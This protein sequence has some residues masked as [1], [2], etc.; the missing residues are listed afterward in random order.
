MENTTL[1]TEQG[2]ALDAG[3]E[4]DAIIDEELRLARET[5]RAADEQAMRD[6]EVWCRTYSSASS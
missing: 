2:E 1:T 4:F 5:Q 3:R 6:E